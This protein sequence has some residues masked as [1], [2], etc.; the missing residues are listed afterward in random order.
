[1]AVRAAPI[2]VMV[3]LEGRREDD[4]I[5]E[6]REGGGSCCNVVVVVVVVGWMEVGERPV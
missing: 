5:S 1:M 4:A 6:V 2:R 3:D